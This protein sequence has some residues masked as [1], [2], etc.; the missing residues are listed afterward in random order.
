[1]IA[2][3]EPRRVAATSMSHRVAYEMGLSQRKVSY[4]IRYDGNVSED[5]VIKFMTDGVLLKE[6]AQVHVYTCLHVTWCLCLCC[7]V[8]SV[9]LNFKS[10]PHFV[11]HQ[12]S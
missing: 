6:I 7:V 1:M 5:T 4:Q 11:Q 3:T 9:V 12:T 8:S 10:T 2:V